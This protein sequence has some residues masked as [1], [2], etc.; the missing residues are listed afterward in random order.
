L[1]ELVEFLPPDGGAL[2]CLRLRPDRYD[3]EAVRRF[4]AR[5]HELETRVAPGSWFG[6]SDRVFRVGF[7][8]LPLGEFTEALRRLETA[9]TEAAAVGDVAPAGQRS[10]AR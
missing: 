1:G 2:C 7:G 3:E 6:E 10:M 9:A 8:H 4:Y 5:L